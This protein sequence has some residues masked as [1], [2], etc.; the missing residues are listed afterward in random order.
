MPPPIADWYGLHKTNINQIA[1][2][3]DAGWTFL[4][5]AEWIKVILCEEPLD[6]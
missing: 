3:N 1:I 2:F 5:I 4:Q 6:L